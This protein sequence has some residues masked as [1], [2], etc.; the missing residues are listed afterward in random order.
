MN[1]LSRICSLTLV[2]L[3]KSPR[4]RNPYFDFQPTS[5]R[6]QNT[7]HLPWQD[8]FHFYFDE[9]L[10]PDDSLF[11]GRLVLREAITLLGLFGLWF[12]YHRRDF[13][14]AHE[15]WWHRCV[16]RGWS[17]RVVPLPTESSSGWFVSTPSASIG[18]LQCTDGLG[19]LSLCTVAIVDQIYSLY[20]YGFLFRISCIPS[21]C[22]LKLWKPS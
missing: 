19:L 21:T 16:S 18:C 13:N 11:L 8:S 10:P 7:Q 22:H 9:N 1:A 15:L 6:V 3:F 14:M 4:V 12:K 17:T 2:A 5:S 20:W